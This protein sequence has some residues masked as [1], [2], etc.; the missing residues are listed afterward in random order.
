[1]EPFSIDSPISSVGDSSFSPLSYAFSEHTEHQEPFQYPNPHEIPA[2]QNHLA[3]LHH[4]SMVLRLIDT[5][6]P[7]SPNTI[8]AKMK[9]IWK[10]V[11]GDVKVDE[12]DYSNNTIVRKMDE[13]DIKQRA[14][15][16]TSGGESK[17]KESNEDTPY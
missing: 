9:D 12:I 11:K 3:H 15:T 8:L 14:D 10:G 4:M 6:T 7:I 17:R 5:T 2:V 13:V 1:M 16:S